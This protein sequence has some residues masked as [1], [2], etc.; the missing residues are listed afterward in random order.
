MPC[1]HPVSAMEKTDGT[2]AFGKHP[3]AQASGTVT[4]FRCRHCVG[5]RADYRSEWSIR[6]MHELKYH[7]SAIFGTF[8]YDEEHVPKNH[9]LRPDDFR[10]CM[11][12]LRKI[13]GSLRYVQVGEYGGEYGRPHHHAIIYG[14]E[15][16]DLELI[17]RNERGDDLYRSATLDKIWGHGQCIIGDVSLQSCGYVA[18]YMHKDM[19]SEYKFDGQYRHY[20][21]ATQTFTKKRRPY[22]TRSNRPGIGYQFYK[23]YWQDMFPCDF[24]VVDGKKYPVPDY[25]FNT[26]L[27]ED[28]PDIYE[29]VKAARE[30]N[31]NKPD[32]IWNNSDERLAVRK[33]C[34]TSRLQNSKRGTKHEP[35]QSVSISHEFEQNEKAFDIKVVDFGKLVRQSIQVIQT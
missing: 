18:G 34:F 28:Q 6:M 12:R 2:Y 19:K 16:P 31:N 11:R 3:G 23:D 21:T 24:T 14:L 35:Q 7:Q 29:Q 33:K 17:K 9:E 30:E 26:L 10:L 25:Y 27:K 22:I 32:K 1:F 4:P 13:M 15:L 20:N 8:T 5:C